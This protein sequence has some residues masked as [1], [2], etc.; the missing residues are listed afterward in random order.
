MIEPK[1]LLIVDDEER[2]L[3]V[4]RLGLKNKGFEVTT[5]ANADEALD[6]IFKKNFDVIVTDI[7]LGGMSGI[8]LVFEL[9]RLEIKIPVLVMTAY[10]DVTTAV[11]ALKHGAWDYIQKPFSVEELEKA[12]R[13]VLAKAPAV[14]DETFVG[15][16]EEGLSNKERELIVKA[17]EQAGQVK[18]KAAKILKI[19]ERAI[20]YKI[21]KYNL[22]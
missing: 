2:L 15:S 8:D 20:W 12:I 18:S 5:A 19:S 9:E 21:K 14:K 4:L 10:A 16:L 7:R 3:R 17:L 22:Q 1:K 6:L 13:E 11:K